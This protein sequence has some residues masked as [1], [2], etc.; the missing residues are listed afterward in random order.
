M[1][2]D[3]LVTLSGMFDL[4]FVLFLSIMHECWRED[5]ESQLMFETLQRKLKEFFNEADGQTG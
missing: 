1:C 2:M 5:P 3:D 4:H